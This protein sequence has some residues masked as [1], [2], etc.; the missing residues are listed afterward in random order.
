M[1]LLGTIVFLIGSGLAY[2][3]A[4]GALG[5]N[6]ELTVRVARHS[7]RWTGVAIAGLVLFTVFVP[8]W[9]SR[10]TCLAGAVVLVAG[11]RSV[12]R[13]WRR[14][15]LMAVGYTAAIVGLML[16]YGPLFSAAQTG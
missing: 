11:L 16:F 6:A 7:P 3:T 15:V 2:G 10:L 5:A 13:S 9:P 4:H 14:R 8:G 1:I 12:L